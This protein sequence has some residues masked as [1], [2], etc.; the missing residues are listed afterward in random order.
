MADD[1]AA[2]GAATFASGAGGAAASSG[3]GGAAGAL[4]ITGGSCFVVGGGISGGASGTAAVYV[5]A[6]GT[7]NTFSF[8]APDW[9]QRK[10]AISEP[11]SDNDTTLI[12]QEERAYLLEVTGKRLQS[13][14]DSCGSG[15]TSS[16]SPLA[17]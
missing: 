11:Q 3:A 12:L 14:A 13:E 8:S 15:N 16:S 4:A 1:S 5:T 10:V 2:G 7:N 6:A 17:R 9:I